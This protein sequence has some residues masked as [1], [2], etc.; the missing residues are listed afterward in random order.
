MAASPATAPAQPLPTPHL[1]FDD[2][3]PVC[4]QEIPADRLE[5]VHGR[6]SVRLREQTAE[7]TALLKEQYNKERTQAEAKAKAERDEALQ[8]LRE[9]N[10]A[11]ERAIRQEEER[12]RDELLKERLAQAEAMRKEQEEA[13]TQRAAAAEQRAKAAAQ[14]SDG[15]K[16]E[17]EQIKHAEALD[18]EKRRQL[19]A[20]P[21]PAPRRQ[22]RAG[23]HHA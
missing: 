3:C 14:T 4:D 10:A 6:Y 23:N 15:L 7:A 20:K 17:L 18:Q 13:L 5:E 8:R 21:R 22:A 12:K 2:H 11:R 1:H 16:V 9:E 19:R